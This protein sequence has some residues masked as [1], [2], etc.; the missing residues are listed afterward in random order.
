MIHEW[1]SERPKTPVKL[2][3]VVLVSLTLIGCSSAMKR[4]QTW[5]GPAAEADQVALLKAPGAINVLEV[6]GHPVDNFLLDDLALDY[7]LLPGDNRV[8]VTHKTIWAKNTVVKNGESK[9]HTVVSEPQQFDITARA[10]ETYTFDIPKPASRSEAEALAADFSG[11]IVDQTGRV[12]AEAK[13]YSAKPRQLPVLPTRSPVVENDKGAAPVAEAANDEAVDTLEA[14]K[15]MWERANA[16]E[17]R[18]FLRWAFE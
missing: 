9:V 16:E 8:V 11:R 3:L 12:V 14:L 13:A 2:F 5:E 7:E 6:N 15:L 17:K 1:L 10:G 18:A 4:V